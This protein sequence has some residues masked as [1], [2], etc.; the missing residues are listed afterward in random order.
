MY[1]LNDH[2]F[3]KKAAVLID[4]GYYRELIKSLSIESIDLIK[5]S[6]VISQPAYRLRTFFFDGLVQDNQSF[7]DL[8]RLF[9]RFEVILGDVVERTF[10][11]S[12]CGITNHRY[13]QKRVD[14]SLA[15]KMVHLASTNQVDK[16]I[17][18]A[19][20]QDFLPAIETAKHEGPIIKLLY[21]EGRISDNLKKAVDERQEFTRQFLDEDN[22]EY[23]LTESQQQKET[24]D[25]KKLDP[26]SEIVTPEKDFIDLTESIEKIFKE[27]NEPRIS[28][29]ILGEKLNKQLPDWK[30]NSPSKKLGE[31]LKKYPNLVDV[32][33]IDKVYYVQLKRPEKFSISLK[34]LENLIKEI[35]EDYYKNNDK[36]L[37]IQV[38]G[39]LLKKKNSTW[40]SDYNVK[41]LSNIVQI[42]KIVLNKPNNSN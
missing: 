26:K 21:K 23:Q 27:H 36:N 30:E 35:I 18:I 40:K 8:L 42:Q 12:K 33:K 9:D 31:T 6:D 16:I 37:S 7:H 10:K 11:C 19:G 29:A 41:Q 14:V 3:P 22:I 39:N 5:F 15:V 17:L 20:D 24:S 38:L 4:G 34:P 2:D 1:S 25:I 32:S 28:L 13:A